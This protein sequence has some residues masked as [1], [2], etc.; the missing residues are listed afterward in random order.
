MEAPPP[1][2]ATPSHSRNTR[3]LDGIQGIQRSLASLIHSFISA[4]VSFHVL[5]A[6]DFCRSSETCRSIF[7]NFLDG[8]L[9]PESE[10]PTNTSREQ[11]G[12]REQSENDWGPGAEDRAMGRS[13]LTKKTV[14]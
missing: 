1:Q 14:V 5:I 2:E 7:S 3:N 11:P 13:P 10:T 9:K 4:L 6:S 8:K 12:L